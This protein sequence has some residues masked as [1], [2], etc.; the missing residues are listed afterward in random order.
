MTAFPS[1]TTIR[2]ISPFPESLQFKTLISNYED[3]GEEQRKQKWL[4]PK[5]SIT[6]GYELIDIADAKT[7]WQFYCARKGS[8]E[9]F[10]LF[11]DRIDSYLYEYVGKGDGVTTVF[12][13]PCSYSSSRSLY[14]NYTLL[15]LGADY[16][17]TA[18]GGTDGADRITFNPVL[19]AGNIITLSFTGYLKVR[20][21]FAQDKLDFQTF[22]RLLTSMQLE[23]KG[24]LNA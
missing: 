3:Q 17:F 9:A 12:N 18:L 13:L 22:Y 1:L 14:A 10:N 4:F 11:Y 6:L 8:F 2:Y 20:C 15:T 24:L 5:R 16:T 19:A 7:L 23:L 21:R